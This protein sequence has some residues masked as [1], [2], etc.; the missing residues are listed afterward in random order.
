[1]SSLPLLLSRVGGEMLFVHK[2]SKVGDWEI[3]PGIELLQNSYGLLPQSLSDFHSPDG[4]QM[5]GL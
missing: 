4:H 5:G 2:T 3:W 1:M